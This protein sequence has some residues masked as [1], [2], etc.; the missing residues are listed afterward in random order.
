MCFNKN[1]ILIK[2]LQMLIVD[3]CCFIN[4]FKPSQ[5]NT[6][7]KVKADCTIREKTREVISEETN[8]KIAKV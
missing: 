8:R 7:L 5:R 3:A 4:L 2:C 1:S 6:A